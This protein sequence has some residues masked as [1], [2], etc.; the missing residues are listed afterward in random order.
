HNQANACAGVPR[1]CLALRKFA[2]H[3][4]WRLLL[5]ASTR[6]VPPLPSLAGCRW[7]TAKLG[8]HDGCRV[9]RRGGNSSNRT[10]AIRYAIAAYAS[11]SPRPNA[12]LF[13]DPPS[14]LHFG[15][16]KGPERLAPLRLCRKNPL[17]DIGE[18]LAHRRLRQSSNHGGIELLD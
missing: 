12:G 2:V 9:R 6:E 4:R 8:L 15:L 13:N 5:F 1:L 7:E 14:L 11:P 3:G 10:G 16:V 17:A 18:A